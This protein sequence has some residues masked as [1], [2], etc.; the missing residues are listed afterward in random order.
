MSVTPVEPVATNW[1]LFLVI[2]LVSA[3]AAA[4]A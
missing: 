4:A 1:W 3:V 2:G